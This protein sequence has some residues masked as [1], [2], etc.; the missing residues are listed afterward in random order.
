MNISRKL[1]K[2]LETYGY[3]KKEMSG[4]RNRKAFKKAYKNRAALKR[5][6]LEF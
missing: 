3:S 2:I 6:I 1:V 5:I 4:K